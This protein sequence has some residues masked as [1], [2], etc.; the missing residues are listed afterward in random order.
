MVDDGDLASVR[1]SY[2]RVISKGMFV[3]RFYEI[4][5]NSSPEIQRMFVKTDF[6]KQNEL[7][8]RSL[9]MALLFPQKNPIARQLIEKIRMSHSREHLNVDPALYNLWLDSLMKTVAEKDQEF[10]PEL[11]QQWRRVLQVTLNYIAEGY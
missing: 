7:L 3:E 10:D 9:S 2:G 8:E 1:K 4:F 11:E 5:I 6:D